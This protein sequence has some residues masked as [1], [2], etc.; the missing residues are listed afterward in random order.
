MP[1]AAIRKLEAP[2]ADADLVQAARNGQRAAFE[3]LYRQHVGRVYA[4][5]LR[6]TADVDLAEQL[7]QDAFV[8]AW[9]KLPGFRGDSAFG[10][11]LHRL[12]VNVVLDWRRARS[13]RWRHE[14]AL[15]PLDQGDQVAAARPAPPARVGDRL[16]LERA[17]A[18]LPEGARTVFVLHEVEGYLVR[19][20]ADLLQV[21]EGTVKAQLFRARQLL[22]EALA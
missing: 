18:T 19:E 3:P 16:D 10:T 9:R 11:W 4:L 2:S 14:T 15:D 12:T 13:R 8:Q 7:T 5:C 20:V 22:K 17:L 6:L 1:S 21:A